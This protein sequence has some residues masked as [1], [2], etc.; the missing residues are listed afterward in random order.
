MTEK[1][2]IFSMSL[3]PANIERIDQIVEAVRNKGARTTRSQ[4]VN[5]MLEAD[6]TPRS[7][8]AWTNYLVSL[9]QL[10]KSYTEVKK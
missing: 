4:V 8:E 3:S 1:V 10:E 5:A 6:T 2:K 9:D 7:M